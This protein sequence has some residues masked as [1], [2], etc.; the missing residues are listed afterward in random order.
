VSELSGGAEASRRSGAAPARPGGG[1]P[2]PARRRIGLIV[3]P[4]AGIGG[5]VG[6]KGSDGA[7]TVARAFALGAVPMAGARAAETLRALA[8]AAAGT[9]N[10]TAADARRGHSAAIELATYPGEMGADV[11]REAGFDPVV[12]GSI[13]A[14][15][16][17]GA[18]TRR[19]AE[20]LHAWGAE[21]LVFAGG[22]GTARDV[23]AAVGGSVPVVGIPAGVKIHSGVFAVN[24]RRAAELVAEFLAGRAGLEDREVMDIDE[25]LFRAGTVAARL[26]GYMRMPYARALVQGAKAGNPGGPSTLRDVA[27]GV[28]D[29]IDRDPGAYWIL[30]PGTTVKAV[31]DELGIEKT[32]LGVD[33]LHRGRLVAADVNESQLLAFLARKPESVR[34]RLVVTVIGGQGYLFGRGNQQLSPAVIR[35]IG[36]AGLVVAATLDK[37]H[38]LGG[39]LLVDTGDAECD[40]YLS[41]HIKVITGEADRVIWRVTA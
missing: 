14:G 25:E 32:L 7:E 27:F 13:E 23:F 4:L 9:A 2:T 28:L 10:G 5:R 16:T 19:A 39:P 12:L 18:D 11:A 35:A 22:D 20:A 31:A 6:L 26:F 34:A 15:A 1:A 37:L 41:G 3:N 8:G 30:G 17:T 24:P 21:L 33:L 36:K 38:A 29:E 40:A